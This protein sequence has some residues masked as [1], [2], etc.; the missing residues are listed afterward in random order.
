MQTGE[1]KFNGGKGALLCPDCRRIVA[2]GNNIPPGDIYKC[3]CGCVF[4]NPKAVGVI[5]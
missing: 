5:N 2:T 4:R 1:F 3:K